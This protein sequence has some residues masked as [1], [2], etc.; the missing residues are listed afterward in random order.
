MKRQEAVYR[1]IADGFIEGRI[2]F[3][4][5]GLSE[6]LKMSLSMVNK[7]VSALEAANAIRKDRRSFEVI[8]F[9]RLMLYWATR[10]NLHKD[11]LYSTRVSADTRDIEREL[12]GGTAFTCYTAYKLIFK[13][14]PADY[15]EVYAYATDEAAMEIKDRFPQQKGPQNLF[16]L[17]PDR[18]IQEAAAEG[19]L[20]H[21]SVSKSQLFV[22]LWGL[23]EWY[24]AEYI[25]A[26]EKRLGI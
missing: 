17:K 8:S 7:A 21:S 22:D 11:I 10:R 1:E 2:R 18:Y 19:R 25:K 5:L 24:A 9:S 4:Q 15:S 3:T 16:I 23:K 6:N 12:P 20:K 13:D 14:A 26:L